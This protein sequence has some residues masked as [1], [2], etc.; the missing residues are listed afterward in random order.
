MLG[1]AKL[2]KLAVGALFCRGAAIVQKSA[3]R[4]PSQD[5]IRSDVYSPPSPICCVCARSSG[6]ASKCSF[7]S[8]GEYKQIAGFTQSCVSCDAGKYTAS[9]AS[10]SG[11]CQSCEAGKYVRVQIGRER[12]VWRR[13][14]SQFAN[15]PPPLP[16]PPGTRV[17][18]VASASPCLRAWR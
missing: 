5:L 1:R 6:A 16:S 7:C 13:T 11:G 2:K 12:Q 9:G 18:E 4:T 10:S 8:P 14:A 17:Q 15:S 3:L